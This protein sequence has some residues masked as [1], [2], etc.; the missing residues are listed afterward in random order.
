MFTTEIYN[1][2]T[3]VQNREVTILLPLKI[4]TT[5]M[6]YQNQSK[7]ERRRQEKKNVKS[8]NSRE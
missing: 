6:S 2:M 7:A 5:V 8:N 4:I 1:S 3:A